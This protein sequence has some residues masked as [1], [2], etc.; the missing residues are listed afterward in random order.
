MAP[1]TAFAGA[2][3]GGVGG[4]FGGAM[5]P[6][7]RLVAA[8]RPPAGEAGPAASAG[9][10]AAAR[11]SSVGATIQ[12]TAALHAALSGSERSLPQACCSVRQPH[13]MASRGVSA[14][15]RKSMPARYC[16]LARRASRNARG[17]MPFVRKGLASFLSSK[18]T[19]TSAAVAT[20]I[21]TRGELD[22]KR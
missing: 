8:A 10:F 11:F 3:G 9:G 15:Q 18:F 19:Q 22:T 16:L 4:A 7:V 12:S 14:W 5:L 20:L 6:P 21:L 2:K 1:A 17:D 13:Q